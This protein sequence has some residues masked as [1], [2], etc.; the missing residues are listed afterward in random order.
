M[1]RW[2]V[3][4]AGIGGRCCGHHRGGRGWRRWRGSLKR[5][6][7]LQ[8]SPEYRPEVEAVSA[9]VP[10]QAHTI[11]LLGVSE[12]ILMAFKD[13]SD[14]QHRSQKELRDSCNRGGDDGGGD[15]T[16]LGQSRQKLRD[17]LAWLERCGNCPELVEKRRRLD[18]QLEGDRSAVDLKAP[19][20]IPAFTALHSGTCRGPLHGPDFPGGPAGRSL[21]TFLVF[22]AG[23]SGDGRR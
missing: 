21:G 10:S 5:K 19:R 14:R 15:C 9:F 8:V 16:G 13:E 17:E 18:E 7:F 2:E 12:E 1:R 4:G 11:L 6:F 22:S 23:V 20:G 3:D